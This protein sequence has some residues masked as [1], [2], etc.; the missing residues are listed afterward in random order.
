M[1]VAY[2]FFQTPHCAHHTNLDPLK[3]HLEYAL[4]LSYLLKQTT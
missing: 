4:R 1:G 3:T 2:L